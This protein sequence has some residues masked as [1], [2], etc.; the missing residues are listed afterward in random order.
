MNDFLF[1]L[2]FFCRNKQNSY[3]VLI[4][5]NTML[6]KITKFIYNNWT[7]WLISGALLYLVKN[8]K[9]QWKG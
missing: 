6:K 2:V 9:T 1:I 7:I 3:A 8:V 5:T 4:F